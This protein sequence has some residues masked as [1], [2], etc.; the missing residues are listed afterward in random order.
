M[1]PG[2]VKI[3]DTTHLE[4]LF[5]MLRKCERLHLARDLFIVGNDAVRVAVDEWCGENDVSF[6]TE[7]VVY[8]GRERVYSHHHHHDHAR[9]HSSVLPPFTTNEKRVFPL[10]QALS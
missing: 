6:P 3:N 1:N 4:H 9:L 2:L 8:N 7:N 5:I 10:S